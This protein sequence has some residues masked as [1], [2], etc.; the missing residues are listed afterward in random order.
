MPSTFLQ[1]RSTEDRRRQPFLDQQSAAAT[2]P[3]AVEAGPTLSLRM[4]SALPVRLT[5]QR[6]AK[7][8]QEQVHKLLDTYQIKLGACLLAR[9]IAQDPSDQDMIKV[10]QLTLR[11]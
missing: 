1:I 10:L 7:L 2:I 6:I 9:E 3:E 5:P 8:S 4:L 11:H